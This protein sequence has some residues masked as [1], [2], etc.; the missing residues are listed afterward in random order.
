M[1]LATLHPKHSEAEMLEFKVGPG[2]DLRLETVGPHPIHVIG[3]LDPP[4]DED[5]FDEEEEEEEDHA[6]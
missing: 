4:E 1:L 3:H 2:N 6:E 5:S